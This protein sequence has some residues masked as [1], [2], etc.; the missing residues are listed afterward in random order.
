[1][2]LRRTIVKLEVWGLSQYQKQSLLNC[3]LL[4]MRWVQ[5]EVHDVICKSLLYVNVETLH[6]LVIFGSSLNLQMVDWT[7]L[8]WWK[9][10]PRAYDKV[11]WD[12]RRRRMAFHRQ[13]LVIQGD[14]MSAEKVDVF[15][16]WF[17][18][19]VMTAFLCG[20]FKWISRWRKCLLCYTSHFCAA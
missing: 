16:L 3:L 8:L 10:C 6:V 4:R 9:L 2:L 5:R 13:I 20:A 11:N 7:T 18:T 15:I 19:V 12:A 14:D 1:M 17:A